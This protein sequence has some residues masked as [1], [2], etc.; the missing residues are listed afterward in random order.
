[1]EVK[2]K[3]WEKYQRKMLD[4]WEFFSLIISSSIII[5]EEEEEEELYVI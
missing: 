1:M 3:I 4:R 2:K 5:E